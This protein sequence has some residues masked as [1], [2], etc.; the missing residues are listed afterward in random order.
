MAACLIAFLLS[1]ALL[2]FGASAWTDWLKALGNIPDEITTVQLGNYSLARFIWDMTRFDISAALAYLLCATAIVFIWRGHRDVNARAEVSDEVREDCL[3]IGTGCVVYLLSSQLVW[4]H[5]LVLA[6]PISLYLLRPASETHGTPKHL[7]LVC[8]L[9][10]GAVILISPYPG[11]FPTGISV[12]W[13]RG[14][15]CAI[16]ARTA[17]KCPVQMLL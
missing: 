3:M 1:Y 10:A 4:F 17:A 7:P 6:I 14:V 12:H 5:Y 11:W 15:F 9:T 2:G 13:T 8:W 16:N